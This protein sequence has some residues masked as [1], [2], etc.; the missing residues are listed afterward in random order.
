MIEEKKHRLRAYV[1]VV[2]VLLGLCLVTF[3]WLIMDIESLKKSGDLSLRHAPWRHATTPPSPNDI[4][5]WMTFKYINY[6]YRLPEDYL[7]TTLKISDARYPQLRI[8]TF[9]KDTKQTEQS[10]LEQ[11]RQAIVNY[12]PPTK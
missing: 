2:A 7:R 11:V 12:T 6:V 5:S 3:V 1:V 4:A 8:G 10:A 9:A